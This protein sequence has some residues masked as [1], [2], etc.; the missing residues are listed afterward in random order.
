MEQADRVSADPTNQGEGG[1]ERQEL[2]QN[3]PGLIDV[4]REA[5]VNLDSS[6]QAQL[7]Q[8]LARVIFRIQVD[9][10]RPQEFEGLDDM[11]R[12]LRL[13]PPGATVDV[14]TESG[15]WR[16]VYTVI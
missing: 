12:F 5:G 6:D 11:L 2:R 10:A 15:E 7:E 14:L 4:I 16:T 13:A 3:Y 9:A 1:A 8:Q